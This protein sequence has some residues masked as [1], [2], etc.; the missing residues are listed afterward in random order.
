MLNKIFEL[1]RG[2]LGAAIELT[3]PKYALNKKANTL[4]FTIYFSFQNQLTRF[5]IPWFGHLILKPFWIFQIWRQTD[6]ISLTKVFNFMIESFSTK[7]LKKNYLRLH[8]LSL[9][10]IV[11]FFY[12]SLKIRNWINQSFYWI[13][14]YSNI[15][16]FFR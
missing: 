3:K 12:Y 4:L 2:N 1:T 13:V 10:T 11:L 14:N 8:H 15:I 6:L 5:L 7:I 16:Q 9:I